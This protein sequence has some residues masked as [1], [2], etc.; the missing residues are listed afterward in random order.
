MT[1]KIVQLVKGQPTM[2]GAGVKLVRVLGHET[3]Q[4]TDPILMM[5]AFDSFD[6][7]DYQAGFPMHPHRG[8]ETI[9]YLAKGSIVHEDHLGHQ[10]TITD[11]QAQWM[12]TGSGILHSESLPASQR[13]LGVQLWLNLPKKDKMVDPA[14]QA[15][16]KVPVVKEGEHTIHVIAGE[17][18]GI[19]GYVSSYVPLTF[20][21]VEL[22]GDL[23]LDLPEGNGFVFTL[24]GSASITGEFVGE[25]TAALLN[26]QGNLQL[27]G[28]ARLLVVL[29]SR[30]NEPIA[31]AGP[32]V[33]NTNDELC[34]AFME[35]E[36]GQFIR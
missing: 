25:K 28:K 2:D 34:Q 18:H 19:T 9:T 23:L 13:L 36:T 12:T 11:G 27:S 17:Y 30:L 29:G 20:Y 3:V 26:E 35:L 24:L 16:E 5:D 33:M 10:A 22:E 6:P 8:I 15:I 31:W 1:R 7:K 4:L 14:Y 21:D 32:I